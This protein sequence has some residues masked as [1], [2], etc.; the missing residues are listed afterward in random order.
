MARGVRALRRQGGAL[1]AA[2]RAWLPLDSSCLSLRKLLGRGRKSGRAGPRFFAGRAP[3]GAAG[4]AGAASRVELCCSRGRAATGDAPIGPNPCGAACCD[5][6]TGVGPAAALHKFCSQRSIA[7]A[8]NGAH[9]PR[10]ED[11]R[12]CPT[13]STSC[14]PQSSGAPPNSV[15]CPIT[16]QVGRTAAARP[17]RRPGQCTARL[18]H[19]QGLATSHRPLRRLRGGCRRQNGRACPSSGVP[20]SLREASPLSPV[21][22]PSAGPWAPAHRRA[23]PR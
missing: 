8:R 21:L 22:H 20:A 19:E 15:D 9:L 23:T 18:P 4:R 11:T 2:L 5:V 10:A 17:S 1:R 12:P 6:L 3:S 7:S 16:H 14:F 13:S